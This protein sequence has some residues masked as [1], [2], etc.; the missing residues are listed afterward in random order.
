MNPVSFESSNTTYLNR[1]ELMFP[2]NF[3]QSNI[4]FDR[5]Q[6]MTDEECEALCCWKGQ[7]TEGNHIVVSCW[8]VTQEELEEINKTGR[9]WAYHFGGVLQP[10][11][12]SGTNPF[13]KKESV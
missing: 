11:C 13:E 8:K 9:V 12:L 2:T 1:D 6:N 7:D 5:P 3:E 10:H 4:V